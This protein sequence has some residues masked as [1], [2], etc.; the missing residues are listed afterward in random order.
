MRS[1]PGAGVEIFLVTCPRFL[2]A[3][4]LTHENYLV[5]LQIEVC[6]F[7]VTLYLL[8]SSFACKVTTFSS[9]CHILL[10][11]VNLRSVITITPK[12]T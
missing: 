12:I 3:F 9:N 4:L 1:R 6:S 11:I 8:S 10:Y 5:T 7:S 2:V